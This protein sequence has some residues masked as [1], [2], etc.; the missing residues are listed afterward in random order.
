MINIGSFFCLKKKPTKERVRPTS[1]EKKHLT[2]SFRCFLRK[3]PSFTHV[4]L[5]KEPEITSTPLKIKMEH[6]L[7]EVWKIMFLSK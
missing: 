4:P 5:L 1:E 6:V 3:S 2:A 7:M